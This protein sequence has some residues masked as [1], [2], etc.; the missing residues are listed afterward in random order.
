MDNEVF[1]KEGLGEFIKR[2][3]PDEVGSIIN[4][5]YRDFATWFAQMDQSVEWKNISFRYNYRFL[6]KTGTYTNI[7]EHVYVLEVDSEKRASLILGNVIPFGKDEVLPIK[8]A[9]NLHKY[10][11]IETLYSGKYNT[12]KEIY[13]ITKREVDILMNLAM[14]KTS[15]EIARSLI[16]SPNTVDT[17]R[18]NLLKKLQCDSVV[19]LAQIAFKSGLL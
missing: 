11:V 10:D 18:R 1:L 7:I 13:K 6:N 16:I 12:A 15:K 2:I 8:S 17:H 14:G 5:V 9:L 3:H 19:E 4:G